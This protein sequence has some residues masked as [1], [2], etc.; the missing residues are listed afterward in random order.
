MVRFKR[1]AIMT[2]FGTAA[3]GM[4]MNTLPAEA[5]QISGITSSQLVVSAEKATATDAE[6]SDADSKEKN[7]DGISDES[8]SNK[9]ELSGWVYNQAYEGYAY[10]KDNSPV[11][12]WNT[13]DGRKYFFDTNGILMEGFQTIGTTLYYLGSFDSDAAL[14]SDEQGVD[15]ANAEELA[16]ETG[17]VYVNSK[18]YYVDE[19]LKVATGRVNIEGGDYIFDEDGAMLTGWQQFDD[20][21]YHLGKSPEDK[22]VSKNCYIDGWYLGTDGA[23]DDETTGDWYKGDWGWWFENNK[24]WYPTDQWLSVDGTWY[25]FGEDGYMIRSTWKEIDGQYYYFNF[26]GSLQEKAEKPNGE[27]TGQWIDGYYV[28]HSGAWTGDSAYW[29]WDGYGYKLWSSDDS[30]HATST[31][32]IIDN[33]Y[34]SFDSQG[35]AYSGGVRCYN[36]PP[37]GGAPSE[38]KNKVI[39]YAAASLGFPYVY[40]GGTMAGTDCSGF[41]MLS[42][43]SEGYSL[44]HNAGAQFATFAANEVWMSEVQPGDMLFYYSGDVENDCGTGIGHVAMYIGNGETLE[45]GDTTNGRRWLADKAAYVTK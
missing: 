41:V 5:A 15:D 28:D 42:Y 33:E 2:A 38:S 19:E 18:Y 8:A 11:R 16:N 45:A 1:L 13:I 9:K 22:G 26:D 17:F 40:G 43:Q 10:Y 12:G 31:T 30:W 23:R 21:W 36:V 3:L 34:I 24:G 39:Q 7:A 37:M 14:A 27:P 29:E 4:G 6:K 25:Y 20:K 35:Y 44:P 32:E